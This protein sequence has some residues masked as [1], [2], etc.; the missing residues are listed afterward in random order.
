[1]DKI[2]RDNI[3]ITFHDIHSPEWLRNTLQVIGSFYEFVS[4]DQVLEVYRSGKT[5]KG[6]CHITFDDGHHSFF[7]NS[8]PVLEELG[9]PATIFVSPSIIL[10]RKNFWFQEVAGLDAEIFMDDLAY[11]LQVDGTLLKQFSVFAILKSLP[12]RTILK[13]IDQHLHRRGLSYREPQN[14]SVEELLEVDRSDLVT[15]GAHTMNHPILRNETDESARYE[16]EASVA[17]LS[18]I[19]GN[20]VRY[21]AYPNGIPEWDF[22]QREMNF[23]QNCGV[24]LSFSTEK[25]GFLPADHPMAIPRYVFEWGGKNL[26][27]TKLLFGQNWYKLKSLVSTDGEFQ[28]RKL[29]SKIIVHSTS[30]L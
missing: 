27:R 2:L 9:V 28:Q 11:F 3:C 20:Q 12:I 13:A 26:V 1:M 17:G 21:F 18:D 4:A 6:I 10:E 25:K 7:D 16:I 22:G 23:L 30:S 24:Q 29:L 15:I 19:L 14:M 8:L 5:H